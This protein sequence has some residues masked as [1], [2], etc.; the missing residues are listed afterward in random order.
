MVKR[1]RKTP[2]SI[3]TDGAPGL[4]KAVEAM[5]PK[6]LR[7]RCWAH[8]A[9]NIVDKVPE[10]TRAEIKAYLGTIREAPTP[11]A[12]KEAAEEV[13]ERYKRQYPSAIKSLADDLEA[14]LAHLQ[15]PVAHR[16]FVRTTNLIERSFEEERR[17]LK[18]Y[19]GFLMSTAF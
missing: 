19:R 14:S 12:G 18:L 6:S 16:K 11:E 7:I 13:I 2:L 10:A 3:T 8:K 1:G 9:R 15:A 5:W 4:I 17:A